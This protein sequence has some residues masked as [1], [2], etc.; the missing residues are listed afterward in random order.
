MHSVFKVG[1]LMRS[2]FFNMRVLI[3]LACA[4]I[5]AADRSSFDCVGRN[6]A[7]EFASTVNPALTTSQLEE[8]ADAL[9]GSATSPCNITIPAAVAAAHDQPRFRSF[10]VKAKEAS[11]VFYVSSHLACSWHSAPHLPQLPFCLQIDYANG[12]DNNAG[13]QAAPFKTIV[14]GLTATRGAGPDGTLV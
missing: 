4:A 9:V 5:V 8:I 7:V 10:P 14:R 13:T 11:A 1:I 3:V 2:D 6:L 12:N